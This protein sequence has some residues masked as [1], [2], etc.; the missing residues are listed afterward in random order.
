MKKGEL[1]YNIMASFFSEF[2][3]IATLR[4]IRFVIHYRL[5]RLLGRKETNYFDAN[6]FFNQTAGNRHHPVR[7]RHANRKRA[8][9]D[10]K[11]SHIMRTVG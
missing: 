7:R 8:V 4:R 1:R 6:I 11:Q 2:I 5:S 3:K 10:Y 9:R